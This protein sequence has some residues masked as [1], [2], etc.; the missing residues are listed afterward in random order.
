MALVAGTTQTKYR[1]CSG[2]I[3]QL[4]NMRGHLA[5]TPR[6]DYSEPSSI[7]VLQKSMS[8]IGQQHCRQWYWRGDCRK[9]KPRTALADRLHIATGV[10]PPRNAVMFAPPGS[11]YVHRS[12][13]IH[14]CLELWCAKGR[15]AAAG[16]P[17]RGPATPTEG[18]ATDAARGAASPTLPCPPPDRGRFVRGARGYPTPTTGRRLDGPPFALFARPGPVGVGSRRRIGA[19]SRP[20][21][22]ALVLWPRRIGV[23]EQ[24]V[25]ENRVLKS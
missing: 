23:S 1:K 14:W 11:A 12:Y 3:G 21:G 22:P 17:L 18:L 15:S 6:N 24:A 13:G 4:S 16:A 2:N 8:L 9:R 25:Q 7:A 10:A 5:E 20:S 19:H